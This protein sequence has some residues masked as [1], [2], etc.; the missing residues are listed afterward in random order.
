MSAIDDPN[1][2]Q[3]VRIEEALK[4]VRDAQGSCQR[5]HTQMFQHLEDSVRGLAIRVANVES[6]CH[7]LEGCVRS[8]KANTSMLHVVLPT[9]LLPT[10][11]IIAI[12]LY[13]IDSRLDQLDVQFSAVAAKQINNI[14]ERRL[15]IEDLQT[16]IKRIEDKLK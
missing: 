9:V 16:R 2:A 15:Q 3:I 7:H 6:A 10:V 14:A 13:R 4:G 1:Y 8:T 11:L 5:S 12:L